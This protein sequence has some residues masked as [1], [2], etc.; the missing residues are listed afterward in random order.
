MALSTAVRKAASVVASPPDEIAQEVPHDRDHSLDKLLAYCRKNWGRVRKAGQKKSDSP[1]NESTAQPSPSTNAIT[2]GAALKTKEQVI[3]Q[4]QPDSPTVDPNRILNSR[5]SEL[6]NGTRPNVEPEASILPEGTNAVSG[7]HILRTESLP[8]ANLPQISEVPG[9]TENEQLPSIS[10]AVDFSVT[11]LDPVSHETQANALCTDTC[12]QTESPETTIQPP[13]DGPDVLSP[14]SD[15]TFEPLSG[16]A[17]GVEIESKWKRLPPFRFFGDNMFLATGLSPDEDY[18]RQW[19]DIWEP[20]SRDKIETLSIDDVDIF[21]IGLRMV[22]SKAKVENMKPTILA[23]CSASVTQKLKTGLSEILEEIT[24][25]EIGFQVI[26]R[27]ITLASPGVL[28]SRALDSKISLD[29]EFWRDF[30]DEGRTTNAYQAQILKGK[31][32]CY[33]STVGGFIFMGKDLF[34]LTTAHSMFNNDNKMPDKVRREGTLVPLPYRGRLESYSWCQDGIWT[35]QRDQDRFFKATVAPMDWALISIPPSMDANFTSPTELFRSESEIQQHVQGPVTTSLKSI[36][37]LTDVGDVIIYGGFSG[38]QSGVLS[39]TSCIFMIGKI[40]FAAYSVA[41]DHCLVDG[42]SGSWVVSQSDHKLCGYIFARVVGFEWAYMLPIGPIIDDIM[43][44][45]PR[46]SDK[47]PP[48][49]TLISVAAIE[50]AMANR[51]PQ[52]REDEEKNRPAYISTPTGLQSENSAAIQGAA[53]KRAEAPNASLVN[54]TTSNLPALYAIDILNISPSPTRPRSTIATLTTG[55]SSRTSLDNDTRSPFSRPV[56][57]SEDRDQLQDTMLVMT[58]SRVDLPSY[59]VISERTIAEAS[60]PPLE[61]LDISLDLDHDLEQA[62]TSADR[63][64]HARWETRAWKVLIWVSAV[65]KQTLS[66]FHRHRENLRINLTILGYLT[67]LV[68]I[69]A[70][71]TY[72]WL[73]Y[74]CVTTSLPIYLKVLGIG[75]GFVA[76]A[77]VWVIRD[78]ILR[79][80]KAYWLE[81]MRGRDRSNDRSLETRADDLAAMLR[82]GGS[83]LSRRSVYRLWLS[84]NRFWMFLQIRFGLR[85]PQRDDSPDLPEMSLHQI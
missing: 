20:T 57:L 77:L 12:L 8:L 61:P 85:V 31:S 41:L 66:R 17:T 83:F 81:Q 76:L 45:A 4:E 39:K 69:A 55:D 24:P 47:Q 28:I 79:F 49:L 53:E 54:S 21:D 18:C 73:I 36:E 9:R 42:D 70:T 34:A 78:Q 43:R 84:G 15:V 16:S 13:L 56:D 63:R 37:E 75:A 52:D 67:D 10:E 59:M 68:I 1:I 25:K 3:K 74:Y 65:L 23:I 46:G 40:P 48:G 33:T 58:R 50:H 38:T 2:N 71:G 44:V 19:R 6:D 72:G 27:D 29:V 5:S 51:L 30:L 7:S 11:D 80:I 32:T 14:T 82:E 64:Q 60:M 62:T 22:G 26:G 35:E